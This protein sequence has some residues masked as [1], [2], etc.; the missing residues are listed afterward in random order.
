MSLTDILNFLSDFAPL[1]LAEDWDN[2]GLLIGQRDDA[3]S[4]IMTCLTL[5]PDVAEEAVSKGASLVVTHHPI[6]FRAVQKLT[7]ETSEGRMLLSLIRA[8]VAV[9]SPHTSYDSA[10]EGV[11]CQLARSLNLTNVKP[12]READCGTDSKPSRES[13]GSGRFGDLPSEVSLADFVELVKQS[14]GIRNTWFVGDPSSTIRRVGIACGAAAEFM[15][16]AARLGCDVL[17]TGE[18]RF[19]A[20][21]EARTCGIALVLPGHFP[22]ERPAMENLAKRLSRQFPDLSVWASDVESD[23]VQWA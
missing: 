23:P 3:V 20:C 11:N 19:H 5:T 17:L 2:T 1:E 10:Y 12:I 8:G 15:S 13:I 6:L 14:L 9:Y 4:S 21:L 7:D 22:T 18:A 16:D